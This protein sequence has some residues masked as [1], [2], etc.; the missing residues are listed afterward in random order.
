MQERE[1][2]VHDRDKT[3]AERCRMEEREENLSPSGQIIKASV[4]QQMVLD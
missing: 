3:M 2:I 1:H 4:G